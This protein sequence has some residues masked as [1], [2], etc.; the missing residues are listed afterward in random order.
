MIETF[1]KSMDPTGTY[2][3]INIFLNFLSLCHIQNIH[4]FLW[5]VMCIN[6][7]LNSMENRF[8]K[9]KCKLC[10]TV[11]IKFDQGEIPF[12]SNFYLKIYFIL[13]FFF[14]FFFAENLISV[15]FTRSNNSQKT[16]WAST[17]FW[18]NIEIQ[19][20]SHTVKRLY[21]VEAKKKSCRIIII[22][23]LLV[24]FS[25]LDSCTPDDLYN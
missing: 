5:E 4:I 14:S 24:H 20:S 25:Y 13:L 6:R 12:M 16:F 7:A 17:N 23:F 19:W 8:R 10:Q 15:W 21:F 1:S 22:D 3:L 2:I 9:I 11:F 18:P